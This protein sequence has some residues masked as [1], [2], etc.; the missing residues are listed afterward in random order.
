MLMLDQR[1]RRGDINVITNVFVFTGMS[2][3]WDHIL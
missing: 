2:L 3:K 1:Q